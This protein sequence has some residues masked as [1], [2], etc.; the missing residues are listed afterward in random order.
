MLSLI[1]NNSVLKGKVSL[2]YKDYVNGKKGI[3]KNIHSRSIYMTTSHFENEF[4]F[5]DKQWLVGL[6]I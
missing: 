3:T 5:F 6:T 2:T 4:I 1:I